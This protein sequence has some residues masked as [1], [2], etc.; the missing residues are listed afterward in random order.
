MFI[1]KYIYIIYQHSLLQKFIIPLHSSDL[2]KFLIKGPLI[3]VGYGEVLFGF[4]H[5]TK[6]GWRAVVFKASD[7]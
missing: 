2:R 3:G 5:Y 7:N 4:F 1:T 6:E